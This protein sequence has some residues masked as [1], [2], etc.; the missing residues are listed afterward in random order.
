MELTPCTNESPTLASRKPR[1]PPCSANPETPPACLAQKS[2]HGDWVPLG[3]TTVRELW[4]VKSLLKCS[5]PL[6][7]TPISY[8]PLWKNRVSESSVLSAAGVK[9]LRQGPLF[10]VGLSRRHANHSPETCQLSC[11]HTERGTECVGRLSADS[12]ARR[13]EPTAGSQNR[14]PGRAGPRAG[15]SRRPCVSASHVQGDPVCP[16]AERI[17]LHG[18]PRGLRTAPP[19]LAS[20]HSVSCAQSRP[21]SPARSPDSLSECLTKPQTT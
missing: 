10:Q 5:P 7:I 12:R 6:L 14:A 18:F 17:T 13:E 4:V 8:P 2:L 15:T 21:R 11:Q 3:D 9:D 1:G 20:L 19:P 16:P